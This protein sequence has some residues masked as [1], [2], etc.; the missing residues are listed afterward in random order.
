MPHTR[1]LF[2]L[3]DAVNRDTAR[4]VPRISL[5]RCCVV[6]LMALSLLAA[7]APAEDVHEGG[8]LYLKYCS[9]CHGSDGKGDGIVATVLRPKP[10][11]LTLLAKTHGGEF[12]SGRVQHSIDGRER[13]AAHGDTEM[14]VWGAIL[15]KEKGTSATTR[16]EV[17]GQVQLLTNY[18]R[19]IQVQ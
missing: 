15:T 13:I 12:P 5:G 10:A 17:R 3:D 9:P 6:A 16:A 7:R 14:P 19:S 8:A 1:V 11:D 2:Q 4:R 18:V